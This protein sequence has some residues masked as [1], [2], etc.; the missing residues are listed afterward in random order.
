MIHITHIA[1]SPFSAEN[2]TIF[3]FFLTLED[4]DPGYQTQLSVHIQDE[5]SRALKKNI[6]IEG[7]VTDAKTE[8]IYPSK[9]DMF[10]AMSTT[11]GCIYNHFYPAP[12]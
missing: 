10:I 11:P 1:L 7:D 6:K 8:E 4:K 3:Y 12:C 2:D 9:A 5:L